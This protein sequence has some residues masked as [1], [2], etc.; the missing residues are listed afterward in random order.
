MSESNK[1]Y[2]NKDGI[3]LQTVKIGSICAAAAS[4]RRYSEGPAPK[5]EKAI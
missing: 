1:M 5:Q 2:F 3:P 4:C